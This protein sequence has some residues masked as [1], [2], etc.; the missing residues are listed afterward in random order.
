MVHLLREIHALLERHPADAVYDRARRRC[1]P[2]CWPPAPPY[3]GG[4]AR[5]VPH[6]V[7]CRRTR[8][9]LPGLFS[10]VGDPAV[11][12]TNNGAERSIRPVVVQ[13]KRSGGTRSPAGTTAFTRLAS[14]FG[15]W[16]A[17]G[18]DPLIAW[19]RLLL[20]PAPALRP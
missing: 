14:L 10:F 9:Y 16:R 17:R 4:A 1:R 12:S 15:T 6:A 11:P 20:E 8:K 5:S 13:R 18:L 7:L 2:T 3:L 19:Q